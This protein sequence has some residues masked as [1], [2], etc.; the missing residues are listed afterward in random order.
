MAPCASPAFAPRADVLEHVDRAAGHRHPAG[1][2]RTD[3]SR[4]TRRLELR[5]PFVERMVAFVTPL[6]DRDVAPR[7]AQPA[8][9]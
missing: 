2:P 3:P 9:R 1:R 4:D 5:E 8:G 7:R 6:A